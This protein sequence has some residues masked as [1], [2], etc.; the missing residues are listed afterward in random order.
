MLEATKTSVWKN[1][2][3]ISADGRPLAV[4]DGSLWTAGGT[5]E[6]GGRRYRV[7]GNMW[8]STY[9]MVDQDDTPVAAARRVGRKSWTVE[10]GGQTYAFHRASLWRDEQELRSADGRRLGSVRRTSMWRGDAVADLPSL[11][12]PV[13]IFVLAVVLTMWDSSSA[14]GAAGAV[15]AA[16]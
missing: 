3:A 15:A 1:R 2:Y 9:G 7:R 5:F 13:Q 12:L 16:G 8:G 14:T 11:Q 10:A 6:L 4:W